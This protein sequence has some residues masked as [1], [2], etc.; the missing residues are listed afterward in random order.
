MTLYEFRTLE[1][2]IPNSQ[3][4]LKAFWKICICTINGKMQNHANPT[5]VLRF[6]LNG[7][8]LAGISIA[9]LSF[10]KLNRWRWRKRKL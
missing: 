1:S 4:E 8:I 9:L 7:N 5:H 2:N 3:I 10:R 6:L